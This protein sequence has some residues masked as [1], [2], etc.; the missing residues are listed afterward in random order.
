MHKLCLNAKGL[1]RLWAP[2]LECLYVRTLP[3][4]LS[5]TARY[6]DHLVVENGRHGQYNGRLKRY[7][8]SSVD[9]REKMSR[10]KIMEEGEETE[11]YSVGLTCT[12]KITE[13][14]KCPR[15]ALMA[16]SDLWCAC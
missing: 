2:G 9:G 15:W 6:T 7:E 14:H 1:S 4:I 3:F 8:K 16:L 10:W 12:P 13:S 11:E 5:E